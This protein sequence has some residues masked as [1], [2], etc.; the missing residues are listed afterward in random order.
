MTFSASSFSLATK[1]HHEYRVPRSSLTASPRKCFHKKGEPREEEF[2]G[3]SLSSQ[4][5]LRATNEGRNLGPAS[6]KV[7]SVP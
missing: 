4:Q 3:R 2:G 5:S 7:S 1:L 6:S